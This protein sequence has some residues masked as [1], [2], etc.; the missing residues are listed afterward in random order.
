VNWGCLT[1]SCVDC[2]DPRAEI[3]HCALEARTLA[4]S[5][6]PFED[7]LA[8]WADG[9]KLY[10]EMFEPG[11][12]IEVVHRVTKKVSRIRLPGPMRGELSTLE[13]ESFFSVLRRVLR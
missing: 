9:T 6:Q 13:K 12:T 10:E 5:G 1:W 4:R 7:W 11:E 3:V 8:A 2:S